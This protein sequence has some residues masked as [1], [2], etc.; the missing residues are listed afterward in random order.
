VVV[1]GIL[2]TL[3]IALAILLVPT[4]YYYSCNTCA[5]LEQDRVLC[6]STSC[7]D[8]QTC[9]S[10]YECGGGNAV[11]KGI[12]PI[13]GQLIPG[14]CVPDEQDLVVFKQKYEEAHKSFHME[15]Y[16]LNLI[17]CSIPLFA[18]ALALAAYA[19]KG[20]R[21]RIYLIIGVAIF[22]LL[23]LLILGYMNASSTFN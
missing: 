2:I 21:A 22:V 10:T 13:G 1:Y 15:S 3:F 17:L 19:S 8:N 23:T 5:T 12:T 11:C 18:V 6:M 16:S 20:S 9:R 4:A 7:L 14:E